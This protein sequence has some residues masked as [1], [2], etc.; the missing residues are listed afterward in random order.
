MVARGYWDRIATGRVSRRSMMRS[1]AGV[2]AVGA[3]L[4]LLG[5]GDNKSSSQ[6]S[7]G[8][9]LTSKPEDTSAKAV[10]GGILDI[11]KGSDPPSFDFV[12]PSAAPDYSG[13]GYSRLIKYEAIKYP[14]PAVANVV[15]DAAMSWE[16]TPDGLQY[17]YKLRP[18][19]KFDARSPTNG[20]NVTTDDVVFSWNRFSTK[21]TFRSTLVNSLD[22]EAP[23]VSLTSPD[24]STIVVK[25]A[26]P[27]APLP[28]MLGYYRYGQ[29]MPVEADS[30]FDPRQDIRGSGAWR[31]KSFAP[32]QHIEYEKNPDWYDATRLNLDGIRYN[33]LP[34]YAS[35]LSQFMAGRLGTYAVNAT[36]VLPT[37]QRMPQL[38]MIA[39]EE[40]PVGV[41]WI[42]FGYLPN[43]PFLD[44]RVRKAASMLLD[45]TLY[46]KTFGNVDEYEK[47]GLT[48]PVRWNSAIACGED[49]FWL[50]P[51]DE[52]A[53][54]PGVKFYQHDP[55]EAKKM[56]QAAGF[57][58]ALEQKYTYGATTSVAARQ[59]EVLKAMW[60]EGGLFKLNGSNV[61]FETE[62]R[63]KYSQGGDK[64]EGIAYSGASGYPDIDGWLTIYYK[65]GSERSGHL[66]ANG[67]PDAELDAMIKKQRGEMDP[68]RRVTLIHDLQKYA[69]SKMYMLND[70]GAAAGF[71]LSW[72]WLGNFGTFR[73]KSGSLPAAEGWTYYWMDS[74]RKGTS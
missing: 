15:A 38:T 22:P 63:P 60:E 54:G 49:Q 43:S 32:S 20:R 18:N 23:I 35:A 33:T 16:T 10:K 30:K 71:L 72:P 57:N 37:K 17:T 48:V 29:I 24:A 66:D 7:A 73:S 3:A 2:S 69:A 4:A 1:A 56:M 34:E 9:T 52:K 40:F 62:F 31:L 65:S 5:C 14:K 28:V 64:H 27:Y 45:R 68:Q 8:T 42:R 44:D 51:S 74:S 53:L 67:K 13:H 59:A 47:A 26:F 21:S 70:P 39:N 61:D 19:L 46:I 6:S 58:S 50:D 11:S 12:A 55:A 36:D 41:P 25:L